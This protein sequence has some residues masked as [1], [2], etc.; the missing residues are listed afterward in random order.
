[1]LQQAG[2]SSEALLDPEIVNYKRTSLAVERDDAGKT[3]GVDSD[4]PGGFVTNTHYR[5]LSGSGTTFTDPR[6][7]GGSVSNADLFSFRK[8]SKLKTMRAGSIKEVGEPNLQVSGSEIS[9]F[10]QKVRPQTS[11]IYRNRQDS[12]VQ[13]DSHRLR[14]QQQYGSGILTAGVIAMDRHFP[15]GSPVQSLTDVASESRIDLQAKM[16]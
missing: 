11:G 13:V 5:P 15:M 12:A 3:T 6:K 8:E 10:R 14:W 9:I 2:A 16:A 4:L 7:R 1:M